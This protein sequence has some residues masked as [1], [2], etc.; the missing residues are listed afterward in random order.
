[1]KHLITFTTGAFIA[2]L[3]GSHFAPGQTHTNIVWTVDDTVHVNQVITT[4]DL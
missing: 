1:M 2:L 4:I 3:I